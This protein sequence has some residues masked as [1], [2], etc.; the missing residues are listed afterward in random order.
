MYVRKWNLLLPNSNCSNIPGDVNGWVWNDWFRTSANAAF[1]LRS[2]VNL[3]TRV[4]RSCVQLDDKRNRTIWLATSI[5]TSSM[6]GAL[7]AEI[8]PAVHSLQRILEESRI[9]RL[10]LNWRKAL[11]WSALCLEDAGAN[12]LHEVADGGVHAGR[13]GARAPD[14]PRHEA[15]EHIL[16]VCIS[17]THERPAAVAGARVCRKNRERTALLQTNT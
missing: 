2:S 7:G 3:R 6:S 8:T 14:A 12:E 11:T 1:S 13:I 17:L 15:R 4:E 9:E 5:D 16:P 10:E